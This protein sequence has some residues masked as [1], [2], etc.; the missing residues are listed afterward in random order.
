MAVIKSIELIGVSTQSWDDAAR[1]ALAEAAKTLRG[2]E[3][4]EVLDQTA[5]VREGEIAEFQATCRIRFR[6]DDR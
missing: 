4:L 1:K 5:V 2:I 6:L 3:H